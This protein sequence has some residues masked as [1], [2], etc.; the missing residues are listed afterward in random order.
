VCRLLNSLFSSGGMINLPIL[1]SPRRPLSADERTLS[2]PSSLNP[3][4]TLLYHESR[5]AM[6]ITTLSKAQNGLLG[7]G[8]T[9]QIRSSHYLGIAQG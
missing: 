9:I 1:L 5:D 3:V 6:R 7:K 2:P 8:P 4:Y